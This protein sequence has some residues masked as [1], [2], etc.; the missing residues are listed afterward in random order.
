MEVHDM[1]TDQPKETKA[2]GCL[3]II[4]ALVSVAT[5]IFCVSIFF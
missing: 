3:S 5:L 4:I 2:Q 1:K